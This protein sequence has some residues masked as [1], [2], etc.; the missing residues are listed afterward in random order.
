MNAAVLKIMI[1]FLLGIYLKVGFLNHIIV[2]FFWGIFVLISILAVPIY[3]PA[4]NAKIS[5]FFTTLS[6]FVI[7][8]FFFLL[9]I[10]TVWNTVSLWFLFTFL[11]SLMTLSTF[12]YTCWPFICLLWKIVLF[13]SFAHFRMGSFRFW[14]FTFMNTLYVL[15]TNHLSD[16][17]IVSCHKLPFTFINCFL[18]CKKLLNLSSPT[19]TKVLWFQ[20]LH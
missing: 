19:T 10:L 4:D 7:S 2:L 20:V 3:I 18:C 1:S 5:F 11:Q 16:I 14:L 9:T 12:S 13:W 8:S 15:D 17:S 6:K